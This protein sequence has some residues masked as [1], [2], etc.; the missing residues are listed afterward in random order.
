MQWLPEKGKGGPLALMLLAVVLVLIWAFLLDPYFSALSEVQQDVE[1]KQK[2]LVRL[3]QSAAEIP[4]LRQ[5]LEEVRQ[6]QQE[7]DLFLPETDFNRAAANLT[8]RLKKLATAQGGCQVTSTQNKHSRQKEPYE[9]VIVQ[10]RLRCELEALLPIFHALES[11]S[12]AILLDNL[13]IS[14]QVYRRPRRGGKGSKLQPLDIRFE[15]RGYLKPEVAARG[16]AA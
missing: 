2:L 10:V 14:R 9:A 13:Q 15:M 5:R 16:D 4:Q 12:P 6:L 8:A 11:Q 1:S 3:R 7:S